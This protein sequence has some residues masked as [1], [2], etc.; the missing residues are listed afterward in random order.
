MEWMGSG[1]FANQSIHHQG[2]QLN[3]K[4]SRL[5]GLIVGVI[6][7]LNLVAAAAASAADP[8]F[9]GNV[10][11][12]TFK[13]TS[14]LSILESTAEQ[15]VDCTSDSSKGEVTGASKVGKVVVTFSNCVAKE[16]SKA[17]CTA[18]SQGGATGVITTNPNR[19]VGV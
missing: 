17:A 12:N 3:M 13:T 6:L 7:A 8:E 15:K 18:K 19:A 11:G 2:A 9:T 16:G 5:V 14:G 4:L 10:A 1:P